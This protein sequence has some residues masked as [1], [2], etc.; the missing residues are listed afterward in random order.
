MIHFNVNYPQQ[1][2][3]PPRRARGP[4]LAISRS[5]LSLVQ[6]SLACCPI[7]IARM[8]CLGSKEPKTAPKAPQTNGGETKKPADPPADAPASGKPKETTKASDKQKGDEG[9]GN[10]SACLSCFA[11]ALAC[12]CL[13]LHL[14]TASLLTLGPCESD[15][16]FYRGFLYSWK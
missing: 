2:M 3:R 4:R 11:R 6:Y 12:I 9:T 8:G 10:E 15:K 16:R 1:L 14:F 5:G 7:P 13:L